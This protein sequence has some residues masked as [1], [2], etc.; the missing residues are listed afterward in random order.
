MIKLETALKDLSLTLAIKVLSLVHLQKPWT[1][2]RGL[3]AILPITARSQIRGQ[4]ERLDK[5]LIT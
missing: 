5:Q 1:L 2:R 4:Q 3:L